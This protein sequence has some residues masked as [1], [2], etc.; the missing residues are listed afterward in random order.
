VAEW[1]GSA[2]NLGFR[3]WGLVLALAGLVLGYVLLPAVGGVLLF[4][5]AILV[6]FE[7]VDVIIDD[8]GLRA[9]APYLGWPR[10][11]W[12]PDEIESVTAIEVRPTE[13]GGWGYRGS[14]KLF[15]KAAWLLRRGPGIRLD[16]RGGRTFIITVDDAE[17]G[18]A[19]LRERLTASP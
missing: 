9:R 8:A 11:A 2:K 3:W 15:K 10:V 19:A 18:A 6:L 12:S 4:T 14:V 5:G 16:L 17:Q 1:R 13:W 7:R